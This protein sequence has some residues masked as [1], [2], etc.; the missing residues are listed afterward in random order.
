MA[1]ALTSRRWERV[2]CVGAYIAGAEVF[3]RMKRADISWEFGKYALALIFLIA[4]VRFGRLP[5]NGFP[6]AYFLLLLPSA[7]LT[8]L[9]VDA[10]EAR[11]YLS[12][13]LSGPLALT[14]STLFFSA[15]R[16][17]RAE[18]RWVY[19]CLLAPIVSIAVVAAAN[20]QLYMPDEFEI[21]SSSLASGG[22]GPNQVSAILGLGILAA[23]LYMVIGTGNAAATAAFAI[24]A[25]F[26]FRQCAITFSRGGLYM[27]VGGIAAAAFYLA[28]D[29]RSRLKLFGVLA[30]VLPLLFFVV[31]PRLE[32]LTG[33][34]IGS[35][36]KS[37]DSTGRSLL[38]QA[39]L[40]TWSENPV[41]GSGPGLGAKN[42]LKVFRSP[43]AHTEYSRLLAEHGILGLAALAMLLFIGVTN[44]RAA[45][46]RL[47]K[48]LAAGMIAYSLLSMAVD[49]MR[50]ASAAFAF[51]LSAVTLAG[52]RRA[53]V[54]APRGV[55]LR[56]EVAQGGQAR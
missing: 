25:L 56:R 55:P 34:A 37:I 4:L 10:A 13:N 42:R 2:A 11:G 24:L 36:F 54:T 43:T 18:M 33:G 20:L 1:L 27:S 48:A 31:W 49:G 51:G 3:W 7:I 28:G 6:I 46:S 52:A 44:V 47:E 35:R 22:Y 15:L 38:I 39:D 17:T 19:V 50:L 16:L 9:G 26:L 53:S 45:P 14:L 29:K 23:V 21:A 30:I 8:F 40:K 5:K 32:A 41:L 12:F